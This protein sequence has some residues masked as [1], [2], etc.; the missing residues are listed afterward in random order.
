MY[1]VP[2][3]DSSQNRDLKYN[4]IRYRYF[5]LVVLGLFPVSSYCLGSLTIPILFIKINNFLKNYW[6]LQFLCPI[7]DTYVGT[8]YIVT[9]GLCMY[10]LWFK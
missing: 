10:L 3:F 1:Y 4:R 8:C 2:L 6:F 7:M 5:H 9:N